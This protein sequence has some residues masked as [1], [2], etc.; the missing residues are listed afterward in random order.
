MKHFCRGETSWV[1][2]TMLRTCACLTLL[3]VLASCATVDGPGADP[4]DPW[5]PY[6]RKIATFNDTL[7]AAVLKPVAQAY[8]W[9]APHFVQQG[10]F[11]F[12]NN[13][14]E[15]AST[16]NHLLQGKFA[17]AGASSSRFMLNSTLGLAGLVDVAS[18]AG[19]E[20]KDQES[21]GQTLSTWGAPSGNYIVLP[22]LGPSTVTDAVALPVDWVMDPTIYGVE[23][24]S[25]SA[26]TIISA[27]D[28]RADLLEAEKLITGDR[29]VFLRE[30]YLQRREYIAN[31]GVVEDDFGSDFGGDDFDDFDGDE[32]DS[33]D[34]D[35]E[36]GD[37]EA[38]AD[39]DFGFDF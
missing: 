33:A 6:N 4:R 22:L 38:G 17:D 34:P 25:R 3:A 18:R 8:T 32:F 28:S 35:A 24:T 31:D 20:R 30:A 16:F 14:G 29:Y 26:L 21:F 11:N 23:P 2:K 15:V 37:D 7:D 13:L 9:A 19:F 5:E 10:V 1:M 36:S 39:D 12:F 27:V